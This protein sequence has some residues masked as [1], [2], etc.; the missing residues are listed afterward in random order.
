M[1]CQLLIKQMSEFIGTFVEP[2]HGCIF[3]SKYSVFKHYLKDYGKLAI[4][5]CITVISNV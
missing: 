4:A 3:C 1:N 2:M 5:R